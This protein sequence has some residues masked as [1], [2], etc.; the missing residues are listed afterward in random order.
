MVSVGVWIMSDGVCR[1]LDCVLWCLWESGCC[2]MVSVL[3][4]NVSNKW[5]GHW[6]EKQL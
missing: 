4:G 1:C 3:P 6:A 2:L 5:D